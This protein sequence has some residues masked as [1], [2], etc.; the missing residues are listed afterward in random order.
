[1]FTN[2]GIAI[3]VIGKSVNFAP[4]N[5]AMQVRMNIV[6]FGGRAVIDIASDIAVEL[7]FFQL[8]NRDQF[9]VS[10]VPANFFINSL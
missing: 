3:P 2:T 7:L 5:T 1:L 9:A 4:G 6:W 10:E 8:C